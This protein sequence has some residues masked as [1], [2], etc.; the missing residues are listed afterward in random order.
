MN[1]GFKKTERVRVPAA[2]RLA[3]CLQ[4]LAIQ[5]LGGAGGKVV[6]GVQQRTKVLVHALTAAIGCV[7]S[8]VRAP[9]SLEAGFVDPLDGAAASAGLHERPVVFIPPAKPTH[10][11]LH[12]RHLGGG[13]L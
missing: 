13:P 6:L 12:N 8:R 11:L 4:R 10:L 2:E 5:W 7:L 1:Q 3:P 9:P